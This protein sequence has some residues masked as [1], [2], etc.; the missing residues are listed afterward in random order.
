MSARLLTP[1]VVGK[2]AAVEAGVAGIERERVVQAECA[3]E[4]EVQ[5]SD[6]QRADEDRQHSQGH[7]QQDEEGSFGVDVS[8]DQTNDQTDQQQHGGVEHREPVTLRQDMNSL[9]H[10]DRLRDGVKKPH[11]INP[12][13]EQPISPIKYSGFV[14][15]SSDNKGTFI[16]ACE[17][18]TNTTQQR[19][20]G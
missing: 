11:D 9:R 2:R 1:Q 14:T 5:C 15:N 19:I 18:L 13:E 20:K 17:I 6:K 12:T 4:A 3:C 7:H 16:T 8:A 10:A